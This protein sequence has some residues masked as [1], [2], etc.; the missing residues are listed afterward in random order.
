MN[1]IKNKALAHLARGLLDIYNAM[2]AEPYRDKIELLR[3]GSGQPTQQR[4]PDDRFGTFP[5]PAA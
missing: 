3:K 5:I 2:G 4:H 1:T